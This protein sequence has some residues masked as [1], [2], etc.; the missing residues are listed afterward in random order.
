MSEHSWWWQNDEG[1]RRWEQFDEFNSFALEQAYS[2]DRQVAILE[3]AG[4][5]VLRVHHVSDDV[6]FVVGYWQQQCVCFDT[7]FAC[8]DEQGLREEAWWRIWGT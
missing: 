1:G 8:L 5:S 3:F 6:G 2:D 7:R 4:A